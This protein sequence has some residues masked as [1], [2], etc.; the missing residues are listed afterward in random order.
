MM[1]VK[2]KMQFFTEIGSKYKLLIER[3]PGL[4]VRFY[5]NIHQYHRISNYVYTNPEKIKKLE[6]FI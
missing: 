1:Y 6:G 3:A 4:R 5:D 2:N